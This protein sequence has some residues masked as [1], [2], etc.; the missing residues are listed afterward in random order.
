MGTFYEQYWKNKKKNS[1]VDFNWKWP[2]IKKYIPVEKINI[3]DFGCGTGE[4]IKASIKI[5]NKST[6]T[7]ID[8]SNNAIRR[9][10]KRFDKSVHFYQVEDGAK[11]PLKSGSFDYITALDVIEHIYDVDKAISELH[12]VLKK[13]GK[14]LITTPFNGAVKIIL[15]TLLGYFDKYFDPIGPHIRFFNPRSLSKVL[16]NHR[17]NI[18]KIGY[19]GRFYPLSRGFYVISQKD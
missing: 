10:K 11:F 18:K 19:F 13:K 9:A 1:L 4:I 5:S 7:G 17:F 15:F 8:I 6:F 16:T 14:I 2:A 12:R 3:L